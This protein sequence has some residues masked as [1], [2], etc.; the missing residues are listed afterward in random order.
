M[1]SGQAKQGTVQ[2]EIKWTLTHCYFANMGGFYI[3]DTNYHLLTSCDFVKYWP[4]VAIPSLTEDDLKDKS[5]TDYF[6]KGI[7]TLQI[8]QLVIS[9]ILRKA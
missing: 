3:H 7:A 1:G 9:L 6:T 4:Y 5:K 2:R 8:T